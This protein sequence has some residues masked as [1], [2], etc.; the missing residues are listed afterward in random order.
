MKA[1]DS[2]SGYKIRLIP[3]STINPTPQLNQKQLIT[4]IEHLISWYQI[5]RS[6]LLAYSIT[7]YIEA[8]LSHKD[9]DNET[10]ERCQYKRLKK[11]WLHLAGL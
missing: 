3:R 2:D 9:Q 8:L 4:I 1:I 7:E 11:K 6:T 10:K 5:R